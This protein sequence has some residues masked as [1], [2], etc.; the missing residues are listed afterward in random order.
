[1]RP[2]PIGHLSNRHSSFMQPEQ[3]ATLLERQLIVS[4]HG[5]PILAG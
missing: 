3:H 2:E 1:M 4:P 5:D